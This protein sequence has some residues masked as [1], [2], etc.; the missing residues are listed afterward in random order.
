MANLLRVLIVEDNDDDRQLIVAALRRGNCEVVHDCVSSAAQMHAA[1]ER[2]V[3]DAIVSDYAMPGFS[4]IEAL[5]IAGRHGHCLPFIICSGAIGEDTAVEMMRSGAHDY[6]GKDNLAR[7]LPAVERALRE[8]EARF[9]ET[10]DQAAVGMAHVGTDGRLLRVNRKFCDILGYIGGDALQ[11]T[12]RYNIFCDDEERNAVLQRELEEGLRDN[13]TT[14]KRCIRKDGSTGWVEVSVSMVRDAQGQCLY[15]I[16]V[17]EDISERKRAAELLQQTNIEIQ[18]INERLRA[19]QSQL[20]QTEKMASIGQLAAGVAHEINNPIGYV[21]S[22]LGT[23]EKYL[24]KVF[25]MLAAHESAE[26]AL[27]PAARGAL[28]A[29]RQEIDLDFLRGDI[30]LLMS[31]SREG[32]ARVN[33]I[34]QDLKDFSHAGAQ[35]E[36]R[37]A[38]LHQGMD[39]AL[40]IASNE[41]KYKCAVRKEYGA[42]PQIECLPSQLNQVFLNLLIN[43]GH[44]IETRGTI[45]I[46]SGM[47]DDNQVWVEVADS[48]QGIAPASLNR[49]FDPFFTTKAMGKGTGLG[50]SLSYG[51]VQKHN[52]RI[53]VESEPGKGSTFRVVLPVRHASAPQPA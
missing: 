27:A 48:G 40:N 16:E 29:M 9:K 8:S 41:L 23:L 39:S 38:D 44:A 2:G 5:R 49:I 46:R 7:L 13:Y 53:E 11:L 19:A 31:E 24:E 37:W 4:G 50:L 26:A 52:G 21:N 36:W 1:L 34:V 35:A 25:A 47:A 33:R 51:I 30:G 43:A 17:I 6:V 3:W 14:E 42:L 45:T 20:L 12:Y 22:N 28:R 32:I 18:S 15:A 10:F